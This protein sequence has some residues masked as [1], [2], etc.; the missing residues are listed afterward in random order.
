MFPMNSWAMHSK[1]HQSLVRRKNQ[2]VI[3][4]WNARLWL[5]NYPIPS[6]NLLPPSGCFPFLQLAWPS[7][8]NVMKYDAAPDT[9]IAT[10]H[11]IPK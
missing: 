6:I 11:A 2:H 7:R 9:V 10:S 1:P 4:V 8:L 3:H 5:K